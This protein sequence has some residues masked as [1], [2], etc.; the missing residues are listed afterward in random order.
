MIYLKNQAPEL[1]SIST[2]IDATKKDSQKILVKVSANGASDKDGVITSYIW[3]YTTESDKEP[4]N[5]Q[6]TQKPE[7]TFVLPNITEKYYFG[8]ILEDND[9]ARTNS[10]ND[11]TSEQIPLIITNQN[12]NIYLPLITLSTPQTTVIAGE[13]VHFSATAKTI[14][15]SDITGKSEYA[16]DF[17][18]DGKIDQKATTS[19]VDHIYENSG[20]Y[21][22]KVRVTYN[23]VSNT[24]Y[25]TIYV[26]NELKAAAHGYRLPNGNYYFL[27]SSE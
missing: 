26:K 11:S 16:W 25:Q 7:I 22:V 6:I 2:N 14:V 23:G 27:N 15:G 21:T 20:N 24:K 12:G 9:G 8:V 5:V 3:Y 19:G 17:D 13:N 10:A 18:G 4:Q 1:T